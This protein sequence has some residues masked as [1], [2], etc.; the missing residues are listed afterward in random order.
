[1][2]RWMLTGTMLGLGLMGC[3]DDPDCDPEV[4]DCLAPVT[5]DTG[6]VPSSEVPTEQQTDPDPVFYDGP[7][8]TFTP[9]NPVAWDPLSTTFTLFEDDD[10]FG[11][12]VLVTA[13]ATLTGTTDLSLT[14]GSHLDEPTRGAWEQQYSSVKDGGFL[15]TEL[16][17]AF[18]MNVSVDGLSVDISDLIGNAANLPEYHE[19]FPRQEFDT[20]LLV[21]DD[22]ALTYDANT[23]NWTWSPPKIETQ[24]N[25]T[26]VEI[27]ITLNLDLD[28]TTTLHAVS[29]DVQHPNTF[30][31]IGSQLQADQTTD[32]TELA[33]GP[34]QEPDPLTFRGMATAEVQNDFVASGT[35]TVHVKVGSFTVQINAFELDFPLAD[36]AHWK[37]ELG[38]ETV[39]HEQE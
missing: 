12:D 8:V 25:E 9:A 29:Y 7:E 35:I 14:V 11:Y 20:L 30:A 13:G 19:V 18:P 23:F 36:P 38:P 22:D 16:E 1:M 5:L 31:P 3:A 6:E 15:D 17:L 32:I 24:F 37:L 21:G 28:Y 26:D 33:G 34:G 2:T 39:R 4:E 10:F 27:E